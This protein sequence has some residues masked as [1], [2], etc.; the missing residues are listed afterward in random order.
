MFG[1]KDL[2]EFFLAFFLVL[3]LIS[4]LH[5]F[6]HVFFAWLMGAKNIKVTIGTGKKLFSTGMIEV[7]QYYFWYGFCSFDN[8]KKNTRAGNI[9]IFLGGSIFNAVSVV[10]LMFLVEQEIVEPGLLTYQ[11]TYFSLY[12]IFFALLPMPYPDGN[13]SDGLMILN[14]VRGKGKN[15]EKTYRIQWKE[16]KGEWMV[17]DP[18]GKQV[19]GF[20]EQKQAIDKAHELAKINRPSRLLICKEGEEKEVQNYPRIPL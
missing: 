1:F 8:L 4:F 11:F 20:E 18:S 16:D 3:P 2:P 15:M 9:L 19:Q 6:G 10:V 7:R 5:E 17:V 13:F 14:L 12:Y